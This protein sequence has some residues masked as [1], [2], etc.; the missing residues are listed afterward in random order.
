M[1]AVAAGEKQ[2]P[3]FIQQVESQLREL[4]ASAKQSKE[5][6]TFAVE[7]SKT[8]R[9]EDTTPCFAC[10]APLRLID[11]QKG[12]FW[13]CTK[14]ECK[15]TYSDY[16]GKPL[17]PI[18]C[19]KC[20]TNPLRKMRGKNGDFCVCSCGYTASDEKGKPQASRTCKKCGSVQKRF[21][22]KTDKKIYWKCIGCM[23][24][25]SN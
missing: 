18:V 7:G 5:K 2:L 22:S 11:S 14:Q 9:N 13:I 10:G 8:G 12:K 24:Y 4:I 17:K 19:P 23:A 21:T 25:D 1:N 20:K 3:E 6:M 16:R 15:K